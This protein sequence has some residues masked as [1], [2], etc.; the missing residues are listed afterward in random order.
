VSFPKDI[1]R[2]CF[3]LLWILANKSS[4]VF[5]IKDSLSSQILNQVDCEVMPLQ[6][7]SNAFNL[8]MKA[9]QEKYCAHSGR[10]I[11]YLFDLILSL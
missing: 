6:K 8:S 7:T 5:G 10:N 1:V 11:D 9:K 2:M 3:W 4:A